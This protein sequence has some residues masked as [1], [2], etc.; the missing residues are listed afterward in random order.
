MSTVLAY[1]FGIILLLLVAKFLLIPIKITIK[2][3]FNAIIGAIALIL[4]NFFGGYIGIPGIGVNMVTALIVGFLG[5]PGV[6][7][8]I[9]VKLLF[10]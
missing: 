8:I 6:I 1:M 4:I 10:L 9:A 5:V 7:I 2:L 3:L